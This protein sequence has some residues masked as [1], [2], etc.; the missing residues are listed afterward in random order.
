MKTTKTAKEPAHF[1]STDREVCFNHFAPKV[2]HIAPEALE[3]WPGDAE[4]IRLNVE[5]A[6]KVIAP[7]LD[8]LAPSMQ[9][10]NMARIR[11]IVPLSLALAFADHRVFVPVSDK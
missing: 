1:T 4:V 10:L 6:F 11:E 7:H 2:A 9:H 8:R 5:R 3:H